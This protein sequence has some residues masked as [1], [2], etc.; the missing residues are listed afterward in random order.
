[1]V[2]AFMTP[3][4]AALAFLWQKQQFVSEKI[5]P[6]TAL[7]E[8]ANCDKFYSIKA[9]M[10]T[11]AEFSIPRESPAGERARMALPAIPLLSRLPEMA[12]RVRPLLRQ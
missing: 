12:A 9:V 10:K 3:D 7:T 6:G 1:M 5:S 8:S 2:A 11:R 4:F